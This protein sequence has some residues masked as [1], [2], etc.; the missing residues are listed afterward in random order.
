MTD[1]ETGPHLAP[2]GSRA[3]DWSEIVPHGELVTSESGEKTVNHGP[4]NG[5]TRK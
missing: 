5:N 2:V 1:I 4:Y 3:K